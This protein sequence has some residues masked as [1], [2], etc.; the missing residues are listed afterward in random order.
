MLKAEATHF[1]ATAVARIM[2]VIKKRAIG[3]I[4]Y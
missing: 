4:N 2:R 3:W 1:S